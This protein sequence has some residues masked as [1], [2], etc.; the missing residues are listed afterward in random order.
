MIWN[1]DVRAAPRDGSFLLFKLVTDERVIARWTVSS[2]PRTLHREAWRSQG[3]S[4]SFLDEH[5]AGWM[6][7]P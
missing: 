4:E 1:H 7:L 2:H 5:V 3:D 6:L